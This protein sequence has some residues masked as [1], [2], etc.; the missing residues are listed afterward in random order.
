[1]RSPRYP[2][3][4]LVALRGEQ[5]DAAVR[6][7]A[8][9]VRERERAEAAR[10]ASERQRDTHAR[11]VD[12]VRRDEQ[13]ALGR[14]ELRASDLA[15]AGAWELRVQTEASAMA[16]EVERSRRSEAGAQETERGARGALATREADAQV[17]EKDR[18]RWHEGARKK[19][20]AKEEEEAAEAYRPVR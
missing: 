14:G 7:L 9:A 2:L 16:V 12:A 13:D 5:V 8:N 3:E 6:G 20:E 4:P 10:R 11:S 15:A 1:M 17:I 19:A 18:D